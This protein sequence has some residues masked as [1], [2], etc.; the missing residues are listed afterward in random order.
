MEILISAALGALLSW[1][2]TSIYSRHSASDSEKI[3]KKLN[4]DLRQVILETD[5]E[6]ISVIQ[7]NELIKEKTELD[8]KTGIHRYIACPKCGSSDITKG[9][10]EHLYEDYDEV[11]SLRRTACNVCT[12]EEKDEPEIDPYAYL[13]K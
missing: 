10:Y 9:H 5:R 13:L 3:A 2:I 8:N 6:N 1:L 7:L 4:H 12:W 11:V